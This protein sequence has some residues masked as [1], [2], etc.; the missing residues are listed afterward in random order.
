MQWSSAGGLRDKDKQGQHRISTKKEKNREQKQK[1][2]QVWHS[3]TKQV[4]PCQERGREELKERSS[5]A[6]MKARAKSGTPNV[7][8]STG[9]MYVDSLMR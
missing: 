2:T 5:M 4:T 1:R 7:M 6:V 3:T 8:D 9:R